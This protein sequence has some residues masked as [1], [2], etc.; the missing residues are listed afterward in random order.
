MAFS[1]SPIAIPNHDFKSM[2]LRV[3]NKV[4]Q[5]MSAFGFKTQQ[6]DYQQSRWEAEVTLPPLTLAQAREWFTFFAKLDGTDGTFTMGY[7]LQN[8][9]SSV[10]I[11]SA[12]VEG[13]DS[14]YLRTISGTTTINAG[15]YISVDD[16]DGNPRL[17]IAL[18]SASLTTTSNEEVRIRPLLRGDV[19]ADDVVD[20]SL[21][22]GTWRLS[23]PSFEF[24]VNEASLHGF[25]FACLEAL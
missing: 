3:V 17:H 1:S 13:N 5:N 12:T 21:P 22:H 15:D 18:E 14:V 8:Y 25:T 11:A 16:E 7:P 10:E 24:N 6:Y 4:A 9:T 23:S 2:R 19:A 20:V